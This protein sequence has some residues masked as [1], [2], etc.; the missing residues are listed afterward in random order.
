MDNER[1]STLEIRRLKES[2]PI[3]YD[4]L[5]LADPS[6]ELLNNYLSDADVFIALYKGRVVASYVMCSISPETSEIKAIAVDEKHQGKGA[7]K[8]LLHHAFQQAKEKGYKT[9]AIGTANTSF[10][11]LQL[12]QQQ[13]FEITGIKRNFFIDNYPEEIFENGIQAKHLIMLE[14][15]L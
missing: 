10:K 1:F 9:I 5:L 6:R 8:L 11:Q 3:P 2:E 4:L 12:Y 14:K 13:G 7:G 15:D